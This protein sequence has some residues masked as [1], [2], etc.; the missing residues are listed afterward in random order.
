MTFP[1]QFGFL[2]IEELESKLAATSIESMLP[3]EFLRA[4]D[5]IALH[6][7][8]LNALLGQALHVPGLVFHA[9]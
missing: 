5:P 3:I 4:P 9:I 2:T 7:V 8:E 6:Q 1:L